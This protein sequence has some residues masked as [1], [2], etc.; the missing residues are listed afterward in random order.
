MIEEIRTATL[1]GTGLF[2]EP[3]T[4]SLDLGKVAPQTKEA[5]FQEG[6]EKRRK[7]IQPIPELWGQR[8]ED[9]QQSRNHMERIIEH[10]H[11]DKK[12]E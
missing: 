6:V 10:Y 9:Y 1:Q 8:T 2:H 3:I 4:K 7:T 5:I 11:P 12:T